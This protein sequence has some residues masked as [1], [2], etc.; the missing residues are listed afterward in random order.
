MTMAALCYSFF[1]ENRD[2]IAEIANLFHN[3]SL[4]EV[5]D[6][7]L[8]Q[9]TVYEIYFSNTKEQI[10][11][12]NVEENRIFYL[13]ET[14]KYYRVSDGIFHLEKLKQLYQDSMKAGDLDEIQNL[15]E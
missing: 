15:I 1:S 9:N 2:T 7:D 4:E 10:A 13:P 8:D 14:Q 5:S 12:I 11:A 3:F 6:E